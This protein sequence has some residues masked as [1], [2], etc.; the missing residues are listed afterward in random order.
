L[1]KTAGGSMEKK[2]KLTTYTVS[3]SWSERGTAQLQR[4]DIGFATINGTTLTTTI[5][6]TVKHELTARDVVTL[7][8]RSIFLQTT[9]VSGTAPTGSR[10]LISTADL[11]HRLDHRTDL[12]VLL[13]SETISYDH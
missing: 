9:S 13:H 8:A 5:D 11:L 7:S 10:D 1:D 2:D 3:G 12:T 4:E 6:G